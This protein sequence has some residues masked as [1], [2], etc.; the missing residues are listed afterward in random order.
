MVYIQREIDF[1]KL[2][3]AKRLTEVDSTALD[4]VQVEFLGE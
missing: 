3:P 2:E 4:V 1:A